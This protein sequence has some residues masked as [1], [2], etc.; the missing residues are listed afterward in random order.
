MKIA[1]DVN[2]EVTNRR[3]GFFHDRPKVGLAANNIA[4]MRSLIV[5]SNADEEERHTDE[6][7]SS[8]QYSI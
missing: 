3:A 7:D 6:C 8:G 2:S 1:N 4:T 5:F